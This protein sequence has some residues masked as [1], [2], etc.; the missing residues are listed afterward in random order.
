MVRA[1]PL[2]VGLMVVLFGLATTGT[3]EDTGDPV[4]KELKALEG[5]WTAKSG[6]TGGGKQI[7]LMILPKFD[8][9]ADGEAAIL[10]YK[11]DVKYAAKVILDLERSPKRITFRHKPD[12]YWED[13]YELKGDTLTLVETKEGK[14]PISLTDEGFTRYVY[15]RAK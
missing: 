14:F 3:A 11:E 9:R 5:V 4:K 1:K 15:T 2:L 10:T 13:S 12:V 7:D 6:V 8:I